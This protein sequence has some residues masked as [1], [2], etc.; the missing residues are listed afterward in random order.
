MPI[1]QVPEDVLK[2]VRKAGV[3]DFEWYSGRVDVSDSPDEQLE[4]EDRLRKH[5]DELRQTAKDL[6]RRS[7]ED[8]KIVAIVGRLGDRLHLPRRRHARHAAE[9]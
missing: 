2:L 5:R 4:R 1:D 7:R 3:D 8:S 9:S 6:R